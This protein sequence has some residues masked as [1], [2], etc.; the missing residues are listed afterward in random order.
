MGEHALVN[1]A[2]F[3]FVE[4]LPE[5]DAERRNAHGGPIAGTLLAAQSPVLTVFEAPNAVAEAPSRSPEDAESE[6]PTPG[7]REAAQL[8]REALPEEV[9]V[10]QQ[11]F[12]QGQGLLGV[13]PVDTGR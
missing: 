13:V 6:A 5:E 3:Q 12:T 10:V 8:L 9:L 4:V 11:A 7:V 2:L 1:D